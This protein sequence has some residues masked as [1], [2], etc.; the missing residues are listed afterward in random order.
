M[1]LLLLRPAMDF[2]GSLASPGTTTSTH[3]CPN[4]VLRACGI[5]YG[6]DFVCRSCL[7]SECPWGEV[8]YLD[9]TVDQ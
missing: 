3:L 9:N 1:V 6:L 7:Q 2:L 4:I 5:D 8:G